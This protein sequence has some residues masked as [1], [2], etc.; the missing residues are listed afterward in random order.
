[1]L[2]NGIGYVMRDKVT[3]K[4]KGV[5]AKP[6]TKKLKNKVNFNRL[7]AVHVEK[8]KEIKTP[9][10][11][12]EKIIFQVYELTDRFSAVSTKKIELE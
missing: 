7:Q 2:S 1:M 10:Q 4:L 5:I 8:M 6:E 12:A 3:L 11:Q 9:E